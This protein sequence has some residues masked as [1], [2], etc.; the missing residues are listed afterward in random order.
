MGS[1]CGDR[2]LLGCLLRPHVPDTLFAKGLRNR[3]T[4]PSTR[5]HLGVYGLHHVRVGAA[6]VVSAQCR[7]KF[8][9]LDRRLGV[10]C[11]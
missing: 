10:V 11:W 5:S 7:V 9:L 6:A 2:D 1:W 4:G 8:T 3:G